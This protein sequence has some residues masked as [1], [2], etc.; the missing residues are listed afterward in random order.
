MKGVTK[1]A[2][3][4]RIDRL[5]VERGLVE[6]REQAARLILAGEVL[7]DGKRVSKAGALV[8]RD[9]GVELQGRSPF[10]SRGGEKLAHAL[11]AFQMKVAGR[12]CLDVGASTGGFTDCLL[13]RG[14]ARVYAVD[15]GVGQLDAKLRKD[16][17]VVVMEKTNAR[18]LDPRIFGE[19]P[20]LA[21]IDVAFISLEKVLPSVFGVLAPRGEVIALVKPQF[22]VG[23][24]AVGKGGVVRDPALHRQAVARLARYA[25]LRGWHVLGVTASPLRGPK[26]NREFFLHCSSHGRTV[27]DLESMIDKSVEALA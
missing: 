6:S 2:A 4:V 9:A 1:P 19:Q 27:S 7:V 5:L 15:V 8:A 26:G 22:E 24:E 13:Q 23:R 17:R 14:A 20:T 11:D 16:P 21:V 3:R 18:A 25:V 12:V 10:V